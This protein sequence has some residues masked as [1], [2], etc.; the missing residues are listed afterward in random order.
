MS[1][2]DLKAK[3]E[4]GFDD[5][6]EEGTEVELCKDGRAS[7]VKE[8]A[9]QVMRVTKA[10]AESVE[11]LRLL[12]IA[13]STEACSETELYDVAREDLTDQEA[14]LAEANE[15]WQEASKNH[16]D[17]TEAAARAL[18]E[19]RSNAQYAENA[20]RRVAAV[21]ELLDRSHN[22]AVSSETVAGTAD[23][24]AKISEQRASD[25]E[26]RFRQARSN[27]ENERKKAEA[28]TKL[29][30]DLEA[31][32][33]NA[34][35]ELGKAKQLVCAARER[36]DDAVVKAEKLTDEIHEAKSGVNDDEKSIATSIVAD[37]KS[38]ERKEYIGEMEKALTD[39]VGLESSTRKLESAIDDLQRRLDLQVKVAASARRQADHSMS[40]ADQLE[41]HALEER[42]AANL[43]QAACVKA[44]IGV[45][46]S[47]AVLT[48]TEAQLA[49]AER[50]A[51]EANETA[52]ASRQ[53]AEQL[54]N[55]AGSLPDLAPLKKKVE[56]AE[57]S[58][59]AALETYELAKESKE[60]ALE[61]AAKAKQVHETNCVNLANM[62]RD[63]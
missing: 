22:Q 32:V 36:A 38:K 6:L 62:E 39:K 42:E 47:D 31:Q 25:T 61:E 28:E 26:A 2:D 57:K 56:L 37:Q 34:K 3:Q 41:E 18:A 24:E 20:E 12:A 45:E 5:G 54:A 17:T 15:E 60:E 43:R 13:A 30:E 4:Q 58:R 51:S 27:E 9:D 8:T 55:E 49:E 11:E 21:R 40:I 63:A 1:Y 52:L 50:A 7:K 48:S 59:D 46:S 19:G 10:F 16:Q 44:K 53:K 23:A 14:L 35:K 33:I 29:E